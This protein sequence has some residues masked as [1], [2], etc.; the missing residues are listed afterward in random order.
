VLQRNAGHVGESAKTLAPSPSALA[1]IKLGAGHHFFSFS[2]N[3]SSPANLNPPAK[4]TVVVS[5]LPA[6]SSSQVLLVLTQLA[7]LLAPFNF[8]ELTVRSRFPH[9]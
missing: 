8:P 6:P 3:C 9:R 4:F 2:L 7:D 5:P 1:Y